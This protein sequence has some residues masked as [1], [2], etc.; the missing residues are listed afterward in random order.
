LFFIKF[1]HSKRPKSVS[2]LGLTSSGVV[3]LFF[4]QYIVQ[5]GAS[6][7]IIRRWY[8]DYFWLE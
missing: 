7:I 1:R 6:S 4:S 5:S 2:L 3:V 8:H